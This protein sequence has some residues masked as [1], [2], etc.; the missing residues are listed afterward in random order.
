MVIIGQELDLPLLLIYKDD[1]KETE[2]LYQFNNKHSFY[3]GKKFNNYYYIIV[4]S[5]IAESNYQST[6]NLIVYNKDIKINGNILPDPMMDVIRN[7][8][9]NYIP[10]DKFEKIV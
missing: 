4:I 8:I 6:F 1:N 7:N 10:Y 5:E 3:T 9:K 2:S